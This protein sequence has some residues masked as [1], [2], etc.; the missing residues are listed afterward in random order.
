MIFC[1]DMKRK[2]KIALTSVTL[3][4]VTHLTIRLFFP[5]RL[6]I[7]VP[8]GYCGEI[9][10]VLSNVDEDIL[11]VDENGIGYITKETFGKRLSRPIVLEE[12]G[13]N[14]SDRSVGFSP[15]A[16]WAIG[17]SSHATSWNDTRMQ[18]TIKTLSFELVPKEKKGE[19]QYYSTDL[20]GLV[21]EAKLHFPPVAK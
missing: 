9:N 20:W 1:L 6:T 2:Y 4:L 14:V 19:K 3:I 18:R 21:D 11:K 8:K 7:V 12:D 13:T 15:S 10:L 16:F 5:I 17:E